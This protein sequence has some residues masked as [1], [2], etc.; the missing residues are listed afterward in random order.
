GKVELKIPAGV[1]S[2][3]SLRL[4]GKGWYKSSNQ[5]SDL[6][7][8]LKIVTPKDLSQTEQEYYQKLA[9]A[10]SFDPRQKLSGF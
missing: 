4:K 5:R 3:Q 9:Q 8:K 2:G 6:M 1:D 10:S 7:V